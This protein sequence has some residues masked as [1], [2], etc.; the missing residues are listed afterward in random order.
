L[1]KRIKKPRKSAFLLIFWAF[2]PDAE[3]P[4][5]K[6]RDDRSS[7]LRIGSFLVIEKLIMESMVDKII[8][9]IYNDDRGSGLFLDLASYYIVTENNAGQYYPDYAYNHPLFIPDYKIY[10]DST[11]S[12]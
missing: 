5:D 4:K 7:C 6:G 10:S 9:G 11:V 1:N 3:L 2:F 12:K 8:A